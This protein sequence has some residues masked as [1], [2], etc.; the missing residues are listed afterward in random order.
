MKFLKKW[1]IIVSIYLGSLIALLMIGSQVRDY[2]GF[3]VDMWIVNIYVGILAI[4]IVYQVLKA[5][6][7]ATVKSNRG[8]Y[9]FLTKFYFQK[10]YPQVNFKDFSTKRLYTMCYVRSQFKDLDLPLLSDE[11]LDRLKI[12]TNKK[13]IEAVGKGLGELAK[14]LGEVGTQFSA[15]AKAGGMGVKKPKIICRNCGSRLTKGLLGKW[16]PLASAGS[17]CHRRGDNCVAMEAYDG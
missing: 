12:E 10:K 2:F 17:S 13:H 14:G 6:Y 7:K 15:G 11:E 3:N 5:I 1:A 8:Y 4:W 9:L 16:V